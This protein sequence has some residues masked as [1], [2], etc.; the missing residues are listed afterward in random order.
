MIN[1]R[2]SSSLK[3]FALGILFAPALALAGC[4]G[5]G[6]DPVTPPVSTPPASTTLRATGLAHGI[7]MGAA[8]DP[9][10]LSES[11]Y[12]T[13]LGSEFRQLEPENQMKFEVIHPRPNTDPQP[14]DFSAADQLVTFAAAQNMVVRGHCFV[15]HNQIADWVTAGIANK[16]IDSVK[17]SDIMRTHIATVAGHY[18]G[19]VWAWDVVNEALND[20]GTMRSSP[21][22][23]QPGIGLAGKGTAY[24]EQAFN[25]AHAADPAAKLF[26][27]DYSAETL[28]AKSDAIYAM[29]K[30][31]KTR[32]VPID[33]IG[34]QL[35]VGLYF[36]DPAQ[37][38]SFAQNIKRFSDLGMEIH[39]TEL[40]I[41]L[42]S[43]SAANLAAQADLY[44]KITQV[45]VQTPNCKVVQTWGFTDKYSWIPGFSKGKQGWALPFDDNY[46]KKPAFQGILDGLNGK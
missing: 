23:D 6:S 42:D 12:A 5:G 18:A 43:N 9:A 46:N 7:I 35:H 36:N 37:L 27:N 34:F 3:L 39:F 22:Y 13:T 25:W 30:D 29:A 14:Y 41:A 4:G 31:F 15:W 1:S 21:W 44:K 8:A 10:H 32:G 19:K 20:D 16:T 2:I 24:I 45:C 28:N 11:N 40:D 26:Y 33:G 17:L 38:T